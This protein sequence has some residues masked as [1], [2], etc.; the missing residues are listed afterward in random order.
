MSLSFRTMLNTKTHTH[1]VCISATFV[2]FYHRLPSCWMSG[3]PLQGCAL[4][5]PVCQRLLTF[6]FGRLEKLT[7]FIEA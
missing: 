6:A 7:F 4:K 1:E 3:N 2:W 5:A